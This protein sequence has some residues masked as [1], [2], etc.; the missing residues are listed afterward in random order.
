MHKVAILRRYTS[1]PRKS[2]DKCLNYHSESGQEIDV[3]EESNVE[4]DYEQNDICEAT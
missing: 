4:T 3:V 1:W 2:G